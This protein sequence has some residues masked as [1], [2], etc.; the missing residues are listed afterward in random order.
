MSRDQNDDVPTSVD[1]HNPAHARA[2]THD[3]IKK[4]PYRR[5]F[6]EAFGNALAKLDQPRILELGSGPGHLARALL[7]QITPA[8]Y[9]ALDFSLAMHELAREHLGP[10]AE[11]VTF[12]ERDF[13]DPTWPTDLGLFDAV[14]TMQAAH[15]TRHKRHL[16]PLLERARSVLA[17]GGLL[18]YCDH[19]GRQP[20][21]T[22]DREEQPSALER[23]GFTG[24]QL[25]LEIDQLALYRATA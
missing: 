16:V 2:W 25:V 20:L 8:D 19:Y 13:R 17:S 10:L 7:E 1:F 22:P 18:M 12:L 5:Q 14:I 4:R 11:R 9:V 3:T 24:V 15:E 21:L 6:F 23:A